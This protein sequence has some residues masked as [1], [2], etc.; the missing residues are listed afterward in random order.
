MTVEQAL[1]HPTW[2]M[3]GKITIDSATLMNKGLELI[4]AHHLFAM[5]Y[6]RI[7]VVVHPQSIIH[8]WCTCATA[9]RSRTWATRTCACRS[10]TRCTTPSASTCRAA[11]STWPR[12]GALTFEPVGR[13]HL[14]CLRLAREAAAAGGTAPCVLNAANEVAVHAFLAG[15]LGFLGIAAVIA[16]HARAAAGAAGARLRLALRGRR[17]GRARGGRAS[18]SAE[19]RTLA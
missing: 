4:E 11:R 18:S 13:R 3:G 16:A 8:A 10:P 19:R 9:P 15:R 7:D 12:S 1:E 17:R 6:D 14:R 2:A 5:P